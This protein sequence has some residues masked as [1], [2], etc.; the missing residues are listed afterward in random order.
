[1]LFRLFLVSLFDLLWIYSTHS[2]QNINKETAA[3]VFRDILWQLFATE[4]CETP[5]QGSPKWAAY[6]KQSISLLFIMLKE[7]L[8]RNTKKA[9]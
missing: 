1:L 3:K 6:P 7:V 9:S 5:L 2:R 8:P 4:G